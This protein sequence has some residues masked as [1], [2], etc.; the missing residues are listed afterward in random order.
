MNGFV[1][2]V[3][4][5]AIEPTRVA[6]EP[7][8]FHRNRLTTLF[9]AVLA[10]PHLVLVGGPA[11]GASLLAWYDGGAN[12]IM[13]GGGG[14][15]FGAAAGLMTVIAWCAILVTGRYPAALWNLVALYV[16]WRAR[17]TA[18]LVL[19]RD[20]YPPFGDGDYPVAVDLVPP[21][22]PRERISVAFRLILAIPHLIGLSV[23]SLAWAIATLGVWCTIL[24]TG[25]AP[26]GLC[27]FSAG[28]L[29]Y[30]VR[31]EAY[32]LLLHDEFPPFSLE[33]SY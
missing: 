4:Y 23:L 14:G 31:V 24:L 8:I 5:A 30:S 28:A 29:R 18:Y 21:D 11:A 19:L 2:H 7:A 26:E 25:R 1:S 3:P 22:T 32:V 9:R 15:L 16:R 33:Q 12:G 27:R 20:E 13:W 10:L 17:A 6:V